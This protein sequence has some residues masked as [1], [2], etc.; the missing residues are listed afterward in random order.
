MSSDDLAGLGANVY[1][2]HAEKL[3]QR[4]ASSC[5]SLPSL[6]DDASPTSS[7]SGQ[8]PAHLHFRAPGSKAGS[9]PHMPWHHSEIL[10]VNVP[11]DL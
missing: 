10:L 5:G 3:R 1:E 6:C 9:H 4:H 7:V 8:P 2:A 11:R